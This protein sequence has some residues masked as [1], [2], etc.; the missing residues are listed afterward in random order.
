MDPKCQAIARIKMLEEL[1]AQKEAEKNQAIAD[2]RQ[3]HQ[4]LVNGLT[5]II[6]DLRAEKKALEEK[7]KD[8]EG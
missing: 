4:D 6:A 1:L 8:M 5:M 3:A 2:A 7:L